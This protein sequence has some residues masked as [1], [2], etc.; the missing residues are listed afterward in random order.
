MIKVRRINGKEFVINCELIDFLE[1]TPDTV[2]SLTTGKKV[3]VLE[4]VDEIIN[5]VIKYKR[6]IFLKD[7]VTERKEV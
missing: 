4:S 7:L 2:I 3:I 5:K 6:Q 1:A